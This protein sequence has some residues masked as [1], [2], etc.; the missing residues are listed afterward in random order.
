MS[1]VLVIG[2]GIVGLSCARSLLADGHQVTMIDRDPAGDK[3]SFGNAGGIGVTEVV[4][5]S[6]PGSCL[7]GAAV[8][9]R[10]TRAALP[11]SAAPA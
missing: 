10:P 8:A 6:V 11:A 4:P 1:R 7:E 9:V 3:A 2:T 5:A